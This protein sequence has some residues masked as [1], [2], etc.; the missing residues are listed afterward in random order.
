LGKVAVGTAVGKMP[1][2]PEQADSMRAAATVRK[3]VFFIGLL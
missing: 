2:S 1:P 3:I